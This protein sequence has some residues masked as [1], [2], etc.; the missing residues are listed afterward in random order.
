VK[1]SFNLQRGH[2]PENPWARAM[3]QRI[4]A[5]AL[6]SEGL[7]SVSRTHIVPYSYPY[8]TPVAEDLGPYFGFSKH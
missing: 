5:P 4:R 7:G 6:F 3:A 1:G 8:I 2:N